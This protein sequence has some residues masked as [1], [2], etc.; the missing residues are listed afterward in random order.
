MSRVES[1]SLYL[2][3]PVAKFY[4]RLPDAIKKSWSLLSKE[5]TKGY[6]PITKL[7]HEVIVLL[8]NRSQE[9]H[10]SVQ[11]F[12][13]AHQQLIPF[14]CSLSDSVIADIFLKKLNKRLQT[15]PDKPI[16]K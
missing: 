2:T 7:D 4:F 15:Y 16:Q 13:N 3:G 10:E 12:F 1:I 11:T 9:P 8:S 14:G 5:L 6:G